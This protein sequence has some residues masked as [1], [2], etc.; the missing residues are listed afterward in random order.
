M[1]AVG[2]GGFRLPFVAYHSVYLFVLRSQ[3]AE[4][5]KSFAKRQSIAQPKQNCP[6]KWNGT[7]VKKLDRVIGGILMVAKTTTAFY[8]ITVY[9]RVGGGGPPDVGKTVMHL[10]PRTPCW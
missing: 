4:T 3:P 10:A 9:A 7:L 2:A 6:V 8:L 1:V 5:V